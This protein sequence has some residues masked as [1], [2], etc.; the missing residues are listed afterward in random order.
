[1]RLAPLLRSLAAIVTT[2]AL[3]PAPA[4]AQRD[5]GLREAGDKTS[6]EEEEIR[7][8]EEWFIRSRG[9]GDVARPDRLRAQAVQEL[10][11]R[12]RAES[13]QNTGSGWVP[14]GPYGMTMLNWSMGLV[15]GRAVS[16]AVHPTDEDILYLGTASGGVWK[17][18]DGGGNWTPISDDIGTQ[19]VGTVAIQASSPNVVWAGT[20]ERQSGAGA[21]VAYFGLGIFRS[22]DSGATF[23]ARNGSGATAL[24][25][26]YVSSIAIHPTS[27]DTLVVSGEAFCLP[28]GT[29]VG[30]GAFKTTDAGAS[31]T[32]VKSGTGSDVFY[33]PTDPN[34]M[35]LAMSGDGV[36]KSTNGGDTW[37]Q[38]SLVNGSG[39]IRLAIAPTD[40]Q[41]L[42]ALTSSAELFRTATGGASWSLV[43][44]AACEGQCVYDLVLDVDPTD[45]SRLLVG[46]MRFF[47]SSNG[48]TTLTPVTS[49]WGSTQAVHQDTHILRYSR[50]TPGRYWAGGDG[51]LWRTDTSGLGFVNL[52]NGLSLTQ[53]YDVTIDPDDPLKVWGGAEDNSSSGRFGSQLWD[54]TVVTGDGFMNL[55]DP[56]DRMLVFQTSYPS[57]NYTMPSVYRSLSGGLPNTF[58]RLPTFGIGAGDNFP[59]VTPLAILPGVAFV[60]SQYVYRAEAGQPSASFRWTKISPD[61]GSGSPL[62]VIHPYSLSSRPNPRAFK[63]AGAYAGTSNGRIW[64]T[65]DVLSASPQWTDVTSSYPGGYVSD[66]ATDP[67][68]PDRVY[69]TRGAFNLGR[70]YRSTS[71]GA[72]WDGSAT[73]LPNVPANAVAVDPDNGR[74]VFVGTDIGVY[75]STDYGATFHPLTQGMPLGAVVTD[76]EIDDSPFV[77][78]AGT[79]GRGA[80]RMDLTP[81][82]NQAPD[83]AFAAPSARRRGKQPTR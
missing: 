73:G 63:P 41:S 50:L 83:S 46:S 70:F 19:S 13:H 9:L 35:W 29:R 55:I 54:V 40:A 64:R 36:Y 4:S 17:T 82:P 21:C 67:F 12:R 24:E 80:W 39:R 58:D 11:A 59:W 28:D 3:L 47:A 71:G 75:E 56:R 15:A 23:Q 62:V 30:G 52:N 53:F 20:G 7:Q 68:D 61:L 43:H 66:V 45:A 69:V 5:E 2:A 6:G 26:S 8:R 79:Y 10:A 48:G 32:R 22:T 38:R 76:L 18:T 57:D 77:L 51:G 16:L 65:A 42:Y 74:R 81:I 33:D 1:M 34:V 60:A 78:V 31:W 25:L 27:P 44:S 14:I 49:T 37:G 72:S